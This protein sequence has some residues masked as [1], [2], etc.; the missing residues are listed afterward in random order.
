MARPPGEKERIKEHVSVAPYA[1][2]ERKDRTGSNS[3]PS[4]G[5]KTPTTE[6]VNMCLQPT[7]DK[8]GSTN[9]IAKIMQSQSEG[10][11]KRNREKLTNG[12]GTNGF[13]QKSLS[14][15]RET[16]TSTRKR[17]GI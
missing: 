1:V 5:E 9:F 2:P 4:S 3:Y 12:Q 6:R 16:V 10:S 8:D 11:R 17:R 7:I 13:R 15:T 14:S